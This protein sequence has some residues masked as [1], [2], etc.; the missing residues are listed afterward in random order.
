MK[1][2]IQMTISTF[3]TR[4]KAQEVGRELVV[5]R[6]AACVQV[7]SPVTSIY[8]WKGEVHQDTEFLLF[9]KTTACRTVQVIQYVTEHHPYEVPEIVTIP[10]VDGLTRYFDWVKESTD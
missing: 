9:I 7:T 4:E 5:A 2:D 1:H 6:L 10:V 3:P 8:S